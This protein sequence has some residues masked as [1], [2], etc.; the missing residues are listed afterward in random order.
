[1]IGHA[2][3]TALAIVPELT[4]ESRLAEHSIGLRRLHKPVYRNTTRS[5]CDEFSVIGDQ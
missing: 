4:V 2:E 1:M 3:V 5:P